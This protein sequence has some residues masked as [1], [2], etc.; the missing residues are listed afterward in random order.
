M[1]RQ[2]DRFLPQGDPSASDGC[3]LSI[4]QITATECHQDD[5]SAQ[6]GRAKMSLIQ[7]FGGM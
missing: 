4:S 3:A 2:Q 1:Q 7:E 6:R 5:S